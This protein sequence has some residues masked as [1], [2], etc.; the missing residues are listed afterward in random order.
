MGAEDVSSLTTWGVE[1]AGGVARSQG[2]AAKTL[3]D[4]ADLLKRKNLEP[5]GLKMPEEEL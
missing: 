5:G 3:L 2:Q 1:R 4:G